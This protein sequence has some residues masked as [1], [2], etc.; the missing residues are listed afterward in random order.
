[1]KKNPILCKGVVGVVIL[2]FGM[3]CAPGL[4]AYGPG[5]DMHSFGGPPYGSLSGFVNDTAMN[6]IKGALVRV[7]FHG[8]YEEDYTNCS[9]YYNVT[10]IPLCWCMKNCTASKKGYV[11]SWVLLSI[12]G[13]DSYDFVLQKENSYLFGSDF[14]IEINKILES[15]RY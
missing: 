3:A 2:F 1:L 13:N 15:P 5:A 14:A 11:T 12:G 4:L 7:Y 10:D 8:T 6:P 9:G